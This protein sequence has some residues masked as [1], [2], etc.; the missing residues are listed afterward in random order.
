MYG[1][2]YVLANL[3]LETRLCDVVMALVVE[4]VD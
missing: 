3:I 2:L 4:D 1:D